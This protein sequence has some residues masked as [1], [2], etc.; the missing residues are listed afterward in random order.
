MLPAMTD[1]RDP[2]LF[3]E[4]ADRMRRDLQQIATEQ[5]AAVAAAVDRAVLAALA[6]QMPTAALFVVTLVKCSHRRW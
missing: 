4:M 2:P 1:R 6:L 5:T 3:V